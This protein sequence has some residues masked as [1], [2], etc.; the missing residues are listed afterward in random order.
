ML[1]V[2]DIERPSLYIRVMRSKDEHPRGLEDGNSYRE[3]RLLEEVDTSPDL[4]QRK[5]A[6]NLGVALGVAN[7]LV[8]QGAKKGYI[9]VTQLGWKRWAYFVT[10]KGVT[11]K[12][13][14]TLAYV[15]RFLQ[16]YRRVR[17]MLR[18]DIASLPLNRESR[19]AIVGTTEI[20]ELAFL[21]LKDIGVDEI[22][23]F[24]RAPATSS[25]LGMPVQELGSIDPGSFAKVVIVNSDRD[26]AWL[27]ELHDIGV[28]DSQVVELL[29]WGRRGLESSDIEGA[30][31]VE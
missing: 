12:L 4:S 1:Q 18:E 5:L 31:A 22:E 20:A 7:L 15:D 17:N 8:K 6:R 24:D 14:L 19:V 26:G 29:S 16:H 2:L 13:H 10:P 11:R 9:R 30:E 25:F 3:L 21:A 23:V 28:P 27:E